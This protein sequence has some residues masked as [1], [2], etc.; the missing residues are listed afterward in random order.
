M[1]GTKNSSYL[2]YGGAV[3]RYI[4]GGLNCLTDNFMCLSG[5]KRITPKIDLIIWNLMTEHHT[6]TRKIWYAL[7]TFHRLEEK[8]SL[9]LEEKHLPH[10]VPMAYSAEGAKPKKGEK[11][12]PDP[13]KP[14]LVP[15]IHNLLFVHTTPAVMREL[16]P[17][18]PIIQ[19][20]T[21]PVNGRN[22]P[23]LVPEMQM[24]QFIRVSN[25]C[26]DHLLYFRPEELNLRRGTPVR[27]IGGPFDGVEGTF[28]KVQG[29]R[30]R[31]VVV[32]LTGLLAIA[33]EVHPDLIQ[34][35]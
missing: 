7:R 11:E 21:C 27:I 8:V 2:L 30:N 12:P 33:A 16:K 15:A 24:A 26:S 35:L 3:I 14:V 29:I 1:T 10:F 25:S 20:L 28:V 4:F 6:D 13:M 5:W 23:I 17:R 9:F 32:Q 19:Y 18:L 31:R 22:E 34:I